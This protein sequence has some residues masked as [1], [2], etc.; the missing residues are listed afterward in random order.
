MLRQLVNV[1][2]S[3]DASA[4]VASEC[5]SHVSNVEDSDTSKRADSGCSSTAGGRGE[6]GHPAHGRAEFSPINV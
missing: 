5:D 1:G 2:S 4:S 6:A 3:T